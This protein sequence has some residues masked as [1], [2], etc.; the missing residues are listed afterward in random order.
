MLD[1]LLGKR[2]REHLARC[3]KTS[4]EERDHAITQKVD[5]AVATIK[6]ETQSVI[7]TCRELTQE[8]KAAVPVL[9]PADRIIEPELPGLRGASDSLARTPDE[10]RA[11]FEAMEEHILAKA[12]CERDAKE[13]F[14]RRM[15][16]RRGET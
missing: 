13:R 14:Q 7:L 8:I 10:R 16:E 9:D 11:E 5:A 12:E 1:F 15:R 6:R 4:L 3:S 2:R